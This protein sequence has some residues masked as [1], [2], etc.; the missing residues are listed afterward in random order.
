MGNCIGTS[1]DSRNISIGR[2]RSS[3]GISKDSSSSSSSSSTA[4]FYLSRRT[5]FPVFCS[6][7][8]PA[9]SSFLQAED[10]S[11][12]E[13]K[14]EAAQASSSNGSSSES[15]IGNAQHTDHPV[16]GQQ[17]SLA[18]ESS[19]DEIEEAAA[20]AAEAAA[21]AALDRVAVEA[22]GARRSNQEEPAPSLATT[23]TS[24]PA[25]AGGTA[26]L[27]QVSAAKLYAF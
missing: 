27:K 24:S 25:S 15:E 16:D 20:A 22:S 26:R 14:G 9:S 1:E 21:A 19:S 7:R 10:R 8:L 3:S 12:G 11:Q 13:D 17:E 23:S 5:C 2:T 18:S 6:S 4:G